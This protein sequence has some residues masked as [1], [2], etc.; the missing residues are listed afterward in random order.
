MQCRSSQS[1][2][3]FPGRSYHKA[4]QVDFEP[5]AFDNA[6]LQSRFY[7]VEKILRDQEATEVS[8]QVFAQNSIHGWPVVGRCLVLDQ[9]SG[10]RIYERMHTEEKINSAQG[11]EVPHGFIK[12]RGFLG[13]CTFLS[14]LALAAGYSQ[15]AFSLLVDHREWR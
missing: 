1:Y 5:L 7:L 2:P 15:T 14:S 4:L 6:G 11:I 8:E 3:N 13:T 12:G 10:Y 9:I